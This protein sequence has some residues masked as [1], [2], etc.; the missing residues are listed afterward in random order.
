MAPSSSASS[1]ASGLPA[2]ASVEAAYGAPVVSINTT[3]FFLRG[4]GELSTAAV[5]SAAMAALA[6]LM[7]P[8]ADSHLGLSRR[9]RGLAKLADGTGGGGGEG[10]AT[11]IDLSL[12]TIGESFLA[13][14]QARARRSSAEPLGVLKAPT[15]L[16]RASE[17]IRSALV[18]GFETARV[19]ESGLL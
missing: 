11:K 3:L 10:A 7:E 9:R 6:A 12:T 8:S 1:A 17:E 15:D 5:V 19:R 2:W 13:S 18:S 16:R 14:G 4:V